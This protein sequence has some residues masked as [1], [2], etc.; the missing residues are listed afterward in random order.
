MS[1]LTSGVN[2]GTTQPYSFTVQKKTQHSY[3]ILRVKM[4]VDHPE[5]YQDSSD[6]KV[7]ISDQY[8]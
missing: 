7:E 6:S 4:D 8:R 5:N 3:I 1:V 2:C